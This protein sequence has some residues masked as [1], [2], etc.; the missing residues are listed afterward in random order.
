MLWLEHQ[1]H[2]K[3]GSV[4]ADLFLVNAAFHQP[5]FGRSGPNKTWFQSEFASV[6]EQLGT[7]SE[8]GKDGNSDPT[9]LNVDPP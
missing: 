9:S 8:E 2:L 6:A 4:S 1:F 3:I 5:L 7:P